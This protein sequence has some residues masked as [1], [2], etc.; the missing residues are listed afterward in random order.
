SVSL[1]HPVS[2]VSELGY[3]MA[4]N[5]SRAPEAAF[6]HLTTHS[7]FKALLFL[8]AGIVI[9]H[10]HTNDVFRMG[11][12]FGQRPWVGGSFLVATLALAGVIPP[13]F[14]SKEA[15]LAGVLRA[16]LSVPFLMLL[17]TSFLT[18]F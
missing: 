15:V 3:M 5:C 1:M 11:G 8:G 14:F 13:G 7:A 16:H 10:F 9:H 18:A 2:S 6:Q 4:A 17:A 12:L